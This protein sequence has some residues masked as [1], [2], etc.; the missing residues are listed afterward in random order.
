MWTKYFE[1]Q[2]EFRQYL[3]QDRPRYGII[4]GSP[5]DLKQSASFSRADEVTLAQLRVDECSLLGSFNFKRLGIGRRECRWCN[6]EPE[7]IQHVMEECPDFRLVILREKL[8]CH[9][10]QSLWMQPLV[11]LQYCREAI[12]TLLT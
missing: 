11:A 6:A 10:V 9:R 2:K 7:T 3:N 12:D 8:N 1:I 5:T 4:A